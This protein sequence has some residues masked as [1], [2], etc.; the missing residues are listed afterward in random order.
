MDTEGLPGVLAGGHV[1]CNGCWCNPD[2]IH[3]CPT[4]RPEVVLVHRGPDMPGVRFVGVDP[5]CWRCHGRG[6]C[7]GMPE[8]DVE[9]FALHHKL[10]GD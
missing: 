1:Q 6:W 7:D 2:I 4:C 10:T 8:G 5:D 9:A 3:P